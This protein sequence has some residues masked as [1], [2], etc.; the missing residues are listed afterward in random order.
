MKKE[1]ENMNLKAGGYI[2]KVERVFIDNAKK[3]G[4]DCAKKEN[5]WV[6]EKRNILI[7]FETRIELFLNSHTLFYDV[8]FALDDNNASHENVVKEIPDDFT[9][10]YLTKDQESLFVHL[11]SNNYLGEET[12]KSLDYFK[13]NAV[14]FSY[15]GCRILHKVSTTQDLFLADSNM[16][17][18][19][20]GKASLNDYIEKIKQLNLPVGWTL[21][22]PKHMSSHNFRS[23][24]TLV[25]AILFFIIFLM[26][27]YM[28]VVSLM[29]QGIFQ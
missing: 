24:F 28:I 7:I 12:R 2:S 25:L 4:F 21:Q 8:I 17:K 18:V 26:Q 27:T 10:E 5:F 19:L 3:L 14:C 15:N 20:K 11:E 9:V 13:A 23:K 6:I 29:R 22:K 16:L 1:V